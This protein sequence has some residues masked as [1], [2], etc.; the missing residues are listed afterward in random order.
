MPFIQPNATVITV[1]AGVNEINVITAALG[2]GEGG[3]DPNG[4]IDAQVRAFAT[5]YAT[6]M[7]GLRTARRRR[8]IVDPERAERGG[9]AVPGPC[10]A[11]AA[12]GGAT[13][14]GRHDP[15]GRE[16]ARL[17]VGHDRRSDVR[18][19]GAT[20]PSNYAGDG[21]HPNDAGYAFIA[22]EVV[23]AI[24]SSSYPAPQSSCSGMTI[25]P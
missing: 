10:H 3:S 6:L 19:R 9:P 1:F 16:R 21:L 18:W 20:S 2:G 25:V 8:G 4:F 15:D 22:A 17:L 7:T 14:G 24:T 23:K 11:R 5:D 13:R 12:S